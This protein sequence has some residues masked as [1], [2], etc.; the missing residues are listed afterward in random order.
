MSTKRTHIVISEELATEI[1]RLV[2]RRQ[3][4]HFLTQ[5]A[6]REV[7]RLRMLSALE[8]AAGSWKDSD[9]PELKQGSAKLV[10]RMRGEDEVRFKKVT[11]SV[12]R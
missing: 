11:G 12:R 2:G 7:K 10:E 3:R 6:Q 5:A 8:Q 4:S 1:D 9:H